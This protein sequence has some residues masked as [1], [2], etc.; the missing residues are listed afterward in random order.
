MDDNIWKRGQSR[1]SITNIE[2]RQYTSGTGA[3]D[4]NNVRRHQATAGLYIPPMPSSDLPKRVADGL[5]HKPKTTMHTEPR[6]YATGT[7]ASDSSNST[8]VRCSYCFGKC[9]DSNCKLQSLLDTGYPINITELDNAESF[10]DEKF[11][12]NGNISLIMYLKLIPENTIPLEPSL[13]NYVFAFVG[14]VTYGVNGKEEAADPTHYFVITAED[15]CVEW[16]EPEYSI[17]VDFLRSQVFGYS[18]IRLNEDSAT[19]R[20]NFFANE[21]ALQSILKKNSSK[22][23]NSEVTVRLTKGVV[24]AHFSDTSCFVL[25]GKISGLKR[26]LPFALGAEQAVTV[27]RGH[28]VIVLPIDDLRGRSTVDSVVDR[29]IFWF[30]N[31][32]LASS[33]GLLLVQGLGA[34]TSDD[35]V[36]DMF[37][38]IGQIAGLWVPAMPAGSNNSV[39]LIRLKDDSMMTRAILAFDGKIIRGQKISVGIPKFKLNYHLISSFL[40]YVCFNKTDG[41]HVTRHVNILHDGRLFGKSLGI[42]VYIIFWFDSGTIEFSISGGKKELAETPWICGA[43]E[44]GEEMGIYLD[45]NNVSFYGEGGD[46]FMNDGK[47]WMCIFHSQY[48]VNCYYHLYKDNDMHVL[49]DQ[50]LGTGDGRAVP[51]AH[52]GQNEMMGVGTT[53]SS[54]A[55]EDGAALCENFDS[56]LKIRH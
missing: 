26:I 31:E 38:S 4:S 42:L 32:K 19:R 43:R 56:N 20:A 23:R 3:A 49:L 50:L 27:D 54:S 52:S 44:T 30:S 41:H 11:I 12:T 15:V 6:Q 47:D 51:V 9:W 46:S 8:S 10:L 17:V 13:C 39:A 24:D 2:R 53:T 29:L 36:R 16:K 48:N 1:N 28:S 7:G 35:M 45:T 33:Q 22:Y 18:T 25:L 37:S 14:Q 5:Y 21:V 34:N 40:D 55:V